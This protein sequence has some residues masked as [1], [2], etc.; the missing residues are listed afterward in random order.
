MTKGKISKDDI[1]RAVSTNAPLIDASAFNQTEGKKITGGGNLLVL[2]VGTAAGPFTVTDVTEK[3]L[4]PK[5][6]PVNVYTTADAQGTEWQ[7]PSA[8]SFV[9]KADKAALVEGETFLILRNDDYRARGKDCQSYAINIT[10]RKAP[11]K[12]KA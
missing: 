7:M 3:V 12:A 2:A 6:K 8:T 11:K 1:K 4:N 9:D 10:S 5:Y